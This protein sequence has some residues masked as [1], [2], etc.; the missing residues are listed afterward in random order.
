MKESKV[1]R[2][3][4]AVGNFAQGMGSQFARGYRAGRNRASETQARSRQ[5]APGAR[6]SALVSA[7]ANS[8]RTWKIRR[9]ILRGF[10]FGSRWQSLRSLSRR[11]ALVSP[12]PGNPKLVVAI[13]IDQFRYDYLTRFRSEYTGGLKR[14]LD[15][16]RR[17]YQRPLS[18]LPTVTAVGHSTFLTG[19]TPVREPESSA[20]NGGTA[21]P[22]QPSPA[23]PIRKPSLLGGNRY[24]FLAAAPVAIHRRRRTEELRQ[25][26]QSHRRFHQG[27]R[28]HPP[29]RPHR[30]RSLLVRRPHPATSSAAPIISRRCPRGCQ[31][32]TPAAPR[33]LRRST[34]GWPTRCRRPARPSIPQLEATPYS[35]ELIQQFAL[36]ALAAEK[37]GT[38]LRRPIC[39]RS[40]TPPTIT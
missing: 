20:T 16:R 1:K 30:R 24:R 32:P 6:S 28:R 10:V 17:F 9:P 33:Q 39:S 35:N 38:T 13:V 29:L 14:M 11:L 37:L 7:P 4:R 15:R 31:E 3:R 25:G 27:P 22:A 12:C 36:R 2:S 8:V 18:P 40:A 23:F 21:P 26:R 34:N 19:A 5:S